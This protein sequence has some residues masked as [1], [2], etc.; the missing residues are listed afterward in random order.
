MWRAVQLAYAVILHI[1]LAYQGIDVPVPPSQSEALGRYASQ[2]LP[3][4]SEWDDARLCISL[5][6]LVAVPAVWN[7]PEPLFS[8]AVSS[9]KGE[10]YVAAPPLWSGVSAPYLI[11]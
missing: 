9:S 10:G 1:L 3:P 5:P 11:D 2:V 8:P 4:L 7:Y 6:L